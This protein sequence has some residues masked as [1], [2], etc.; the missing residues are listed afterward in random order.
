MIVPN[1]VIVEIAE[2]PVLLAADA[3]P[4]EFSPGRSTEPTIVRQ[5]YGDVDAVFARFLHRLHPCIRPRYIFVWSIEIAM[6]AR[7]LIQLLMRLDLPW[8]GRDP[9]CCCRTEVPDS[10][11]SR[12]SRP[13]TSRYFPSSEPAAAC[14]VK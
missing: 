4:G 1:L 9:A 7:S 12:Y 10:G 13:C 11:S 6:C 14:T 3:E 8:S 5:G 2:L